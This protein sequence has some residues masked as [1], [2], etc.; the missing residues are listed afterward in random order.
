M[1]LSIYVSSLYLTGNANA[2]SNWWKYSAL[3][4]QIALP[5]VP[6]KHLA[7]RSDR[8]NLGENEPLGELEIEAVASIPMISGN[9]VLSVLHFL[10][11]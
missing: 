5:A 3:C 4:M 1:W 8:I 6:V 2:T 7:A 10:H 9:L 11:H